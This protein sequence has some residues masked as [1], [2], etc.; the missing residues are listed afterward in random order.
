MTSAEHQL[1]V[2]AAIYKLRIWA[3]EQMVLAMK[4]RVEGIKNEKELEGRIKAFGEFVD[5]LEEATP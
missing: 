3:L 5:K 2:D 1:F 4:D